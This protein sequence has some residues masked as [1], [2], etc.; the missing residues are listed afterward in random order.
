MHWTWAVAKRVRSVPRCHGPLN[1]LVYSTIARLAGRMGASPWLVFGQ[2]NKTWKRLYQ[3]GAVAVY[4]LGEHDARVEV[5]G[6]PFTRYAL[7]RE[8]FGGALLHVLENY[9]ERPTLTE[10][11]ERRGPATFSFLVRWS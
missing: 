4:R 10:T 2:A 9:C 8:A 6:D 7:H 5:W 1:G 11:R 3:G